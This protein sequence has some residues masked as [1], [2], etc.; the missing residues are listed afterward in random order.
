MV[1]RGGCRS[2]I[3]LKWIKKGW[4]KFGVQKTKEVENEE[5]LKKKIGNWSCN[6]GHPR[7]CSSSILSH[8][9]LFSVGCILGGP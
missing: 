8:S 9:H 5:G 7:S 3:K 2:P 4:P 1:T 6:L